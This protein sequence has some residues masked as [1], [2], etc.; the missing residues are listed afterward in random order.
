MISGEI[1]ANEF[2]RFCELGRF[3]Q[4]VVP[5]YDC[6][7]E[8][9]IIDPG[10]WHYLARVSQ[11]IPLFPSLRELHWTIQDPSSTDILFL[12]PPSLRCLTICYSGCSSDSREWMLSQEML[13]RTIFN[14]A[15]QLTQLIIRDVDEALLPACLVHARVLRQLRVEFLEHR[16]SV[17][18]DTLRAVSSMDSLEELSFSFDALEDLVD[19]SGFSAL[20]KLEMTMISGS[21]RPIFVAFSSPNL[22]ELTL[23]S[24]IEVLKAEEASATSAMLAQSFPSM[25]DLT[26]SL[27]VG[28]GVPLESA[29]APLF[30]LRLAKVSLKVRGLS[31][32]TPTD[33]L[34]AT[35]A[36]SWPGLVE[37]SINIP[38]QS[39]DAGLLPGITAHALLA[40]ARGCPRL[41]TLRLPRMCGPL[42]GTVGEYPV[43]QHALRTLAVDRPG[44]IGD[45][46][47]VTCALVLDRLFP[48]LD[49]TLANSGGYD[50]VSSAWW[51]MMSS[52]RLC[53]LGRTNRTS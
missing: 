6:V 20:K 26:W 31:S 22:R 16:T 24:E 12:V 45:A 17:G 28:D 32:S 7:C 4:A 10:T 13:F 14:T 25:E 40:F 27:S 19:F 15:A 39:D 50:P 23:D 52:V 11:G 21:A 1:P 33:D 2:S 29:L 35:I 37:L 47:Y 5:R 46:G 36:R 51:R 18:L 43:L 53:Q 38:Y 34:F 42:P 48:D 49:T 30:P 8:S 3:V 41:Q 9:T 44:F